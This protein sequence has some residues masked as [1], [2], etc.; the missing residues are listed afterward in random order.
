MFAMLFVMYFNGYC[1][2]IVFVV[3]DIQWFIIV[4]L[5]KTSQFC[6]CYLLNKE[7]Y[8]K[9]NG[10]FYFTYNYTKICQK[11]ALKNYIFNHALSKP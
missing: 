4:S 7:L 10:F 3:I 9:K 5:G 2:F 11:R 6:L 1:V 8:T